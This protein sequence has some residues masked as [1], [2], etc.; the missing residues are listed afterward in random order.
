[1]QIGHL[2]SRPYVY[3]P[4]GREGGREGG[5]GEGGRGWE[6]RRLMEKIVKRTSEEEEREKSTTGIGASLTPDYNDKVESNNI[7]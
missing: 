6:W 7:Q 1:M 4:D 3:R 2:C 5:R